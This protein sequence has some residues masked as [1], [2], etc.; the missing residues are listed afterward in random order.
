MQNDVLILGLCGF[1]LVIESMIDLMRFCKLGERPVLRTC[2]HSIL[3]EAHPV[4]PCQP[5][6]RGTP[7]PS[8]VCTTWE[9]GCAQVPVHFLTSKMLPVVHLCPSGTFLWPAASGSLVLLVWCYVWKLQFPACFTS[10]L[11]SLPVPRRAL[12]LSPWLSD[13]WP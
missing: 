4:T 1:P 11:F 12:P 10:G 5:T 8:R 7:F 13:A 2:A 6:T 3:R 9:D